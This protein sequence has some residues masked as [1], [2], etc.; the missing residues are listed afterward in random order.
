MEPEGSLPHSQ[1][2]AARPYPEP[3]QYS[4]YLHILKIHR[5]IILPSTS[6]SCKW[7][8]SL[9]FPHQNP[10]YTSPLPHAFYIAWHLIILYFITRTILGEDYRA[11]SSSLCSFLHSPVT[12]S[13]LGPNFLLTALLS[14]ALS[15]CSSL[16]QHR[17]I[18]QQTNKQTNK[19]T[20]RQTN[21][22]RTL[23]PI[24]LNSGLGVNLVATIEHPFSYTLFKSWTQPTV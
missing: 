10:V 7:S 12:P 24:E 9:R 19:Q 18:R 15:L 20:N 13:L 5:N 23:W 11:L 4:P 6:G 1:V 16:K 21:N 22:V 3:K 2:P 8:L 14:N 17:Y